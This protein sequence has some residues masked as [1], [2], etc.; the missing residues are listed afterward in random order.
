[1]FDMDTG[2]ETW[3]PPP[4][5]I[6]KSRLIGIPRHGR[7]RGFKAGKEEIVGLITALKLYSEKDHQAD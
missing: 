3:N 6:D 4:T 5:L 1:M 7:G 2:F